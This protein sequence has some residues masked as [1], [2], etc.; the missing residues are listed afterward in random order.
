MLKEF[1]TSL[2]NFM[3]NDVNIWENRYSN[4]FIKIFYKS[5]LIYEK[6]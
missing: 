2:Y 3:K 1:Y 4:K 5:F 6:N